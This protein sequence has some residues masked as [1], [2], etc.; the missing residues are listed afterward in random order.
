MAK[1]VVDRDVP[2]GQVF[3]MLT[4]YDCGGYN[5]HGQWR[6]K[7][8]CECGKP[9][10]IIATLVRTG[11]TKSCGCLQAKVRIT[12]GAT[13]TRQYQ[14]WADM[15][16]RC[17]KPTN[18]NYER[19]GG[20]GI[21]V[22]E[23]WLTFAG[24]WK[25]MQQGYSD[26]LTLDRIDN[27]DGYSKENCRW[28]DMSTQLHNRRKRGSSKR[29][30]IGAWKQPNGERYGARI[31]VD[32]KVIDLGTFATALDAARAYDAASEKFYGDRP[33]GT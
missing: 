16:S 19:Y 33:N 7:C 12:H 22:S 23:E 17:N 6:W 30:F 11:R 13:G 26:S 2:V 28:T 21:T 9:R 25:D 15:V 14:I 32:K 5:K 27:N 8:I 31:S 3:N 1:K 4:V 29:E 18:I 10:N 24:F 20:R